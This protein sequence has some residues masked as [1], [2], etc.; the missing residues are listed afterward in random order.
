MT[1]NV[2]DISYL[3]MDYAEVGDTKIYIVPVVAPNLILGKSKGEAVDNLKQILCSTKL[4]QS[5]D[6]TINPKDDNE[7]FKIFADHE[8][9]VTDFA[10][11]QN[12]KEEKY[13]DCNFGLR[14]YYTIREC[15]PIKGD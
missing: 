9:C 7:P 2:L 6:V 3:E 12:I 13:D 11:L 5:F 1:N 14:L 10:S 4:V 8:Y 15:I